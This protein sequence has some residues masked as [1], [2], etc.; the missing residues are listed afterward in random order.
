MDIIQNVKTGQTLRFIQTGK[1]TNGCL[2]EMEATFRP[3]SQEPLEHYHPFQAEEFMVLKGE[4][5]VKINGLLRKFTDGE[6]VYIPANTVHAMWNSSEVL[7]VVNWKVQ[8]ALK[9]E[10][11]LKTAAGLA[12]DGKTNESGIPGLWQVV[13]LSRR[14]ADSFR[15][16]KPPYWLQRSIF[17]LLA[18]FSF[19]LG[20]RAS[21]YRKYTD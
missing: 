3:F 6:T 13:V 4:L 8:P 9:T 15:L 12:N 11:F 2:L 1:E 21:A 16:A 19:L 7:T 20:Y 5:T 14:Y 10:Q 17:T 18:P